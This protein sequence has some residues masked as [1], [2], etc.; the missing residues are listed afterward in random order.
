MVT[1]YFQ[2]CFYV[3][4]WATQFTTITGAEWQ[5][6]YSKFAQQKQ[7]P[8][9]FSIIQFDYKFGKLTLHGLHFKFSLVRFYNIVTKR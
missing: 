8:V 1:K 6:N 2:R 4:F 7:H 3:S 5:I 9:S